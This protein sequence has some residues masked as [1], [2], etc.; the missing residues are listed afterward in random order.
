[1]LSFGSRCSA[2]TELMAATSARF[3]VVDAVLL[4]ATE[5]GLASGAAKNA[6]TRITHTDIAPRRIRSAEF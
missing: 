4:P 2:R 6:N 5:L 1:M 3:R